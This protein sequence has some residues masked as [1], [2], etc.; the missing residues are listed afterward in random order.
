MRTGGFVWL[1]SYPKSGSTWLRLALRSLLAGGAPVDFQ[2]RTLFAPLIDCFGV[3]EAELDVE[4]SDLTL[5]ELDELLPDALLLATNAVPEVQ[6]RKVHDCW[7]RTASGRLRFPPEATRAAVHVVRDPRDVAV[8]WA[9]HAAIDLDEAISFLADPAAMLGL[10]RRETLLAVPQPL[11]SWSGHTESWLAADPA[12]LTL[13]YEDML[14]DPHAALA[15]V[16]EHCG[17]AAT[18]AALDGA[19]AATRFDRL[20]AAEAEHGFRMGQAGDRIFFRR[21]V[22]GGWRDTLT[23]AQAARIARDHGAMMD[24]LGYDR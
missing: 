19:V 4:A 9:H 15:R 14:A 24:R 17:L 21:G 12:P 22:A 20:R 2:T 23:A 16:A 18:P 7:G 11:S 6:L 1:A 3:L 8:S 13:R 10:S 5:A